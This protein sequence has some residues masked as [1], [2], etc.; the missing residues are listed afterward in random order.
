M[1]KDEWLDKIAKEVNNLES[2]VNG[3]LW[4]GIQSQI[5]APGAAAA[6]GIIWTK[7]LIATLV[8]A[9]SVGT[10]AAI[11]LMGT[12]DDLPAKE[13][14]TVVAEASPEIPASEIEKKNKDTVQKDINGATKLVV[15]GKPQQEIMN[16]KPVELEIANGKKENLEEEPA[17][18]KETVQPVETPK[19]LEKQETTIPVSIVKANTVVD[20]STKGKSE[21]AVKQKEN[22]RNSG[23]LTSTSVPPVTV[24]EPHSIKLTNIFTPDGDGIN[25]VFTIETVGL[26]DVVVV[27]MDAQGKVVWRGASNID[28]WDGRDQSGMLVPK[29]DYVYYVTGKDS[30][31]ELVNKYARLRITY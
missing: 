1:R 17:P 8:G 16:R 29:G 5:V 4:S 25:D 21:A 9:V 23:G 31:G 18:L 28:P 20:S 14:K 3:N 6:N 15:K 12:N 13:T 26:M 10:V 24:K 11:V 7:K 30:T 19:K 22:I 2:P 27:I